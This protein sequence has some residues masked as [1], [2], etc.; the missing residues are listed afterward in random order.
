MAEGDEDGRERDPAELSLAGGTSNHE[1]LS[2]HHHAAQV[3]EFNMQPKT[4]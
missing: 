1:Q 2:R 4:R 3:K